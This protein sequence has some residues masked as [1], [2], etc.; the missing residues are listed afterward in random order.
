MV[1]TWRSEV[2]FAVNLFL[3]LWYGSL[4]LELKLLGLCGTEP[5]CQPWALDFIICK[6]VEPKKKMLM[7][8]RM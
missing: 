1:H 4:G 8:S 7:S 3:L 5:F 6:V 2:N